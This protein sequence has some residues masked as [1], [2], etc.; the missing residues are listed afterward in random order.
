MKNL[1]YLVDF[2]YE[3]DLFCS[4]LYASTIGEVYDQIEYNYPG[5]SI[6]EIKQCET[7]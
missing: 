6:I 2:E 4:D 7:D 5:A 3:G 1:K